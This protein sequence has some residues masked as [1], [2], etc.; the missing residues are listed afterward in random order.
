[1]RFH[2]SN[3][4]VAFEAYTPALN[5]LERAFRKAGLTIRF[6]ADYSPTHGKKIHIKEHAKIRKTIYIE[7]DS[8]VQAI[9]HITE[10]VVDTCIEQKRAEW[11]RQK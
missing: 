7:G 6:L 5:A 3:D 1:M 2:V 11:E 8:P 10:A 4:Q 9:K